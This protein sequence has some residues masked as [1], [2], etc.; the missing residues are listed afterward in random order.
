MKSAPFFRGRFVWIDNDT[1][2]GR[3]RPKVRVGDYSVL[4]RKRGAKALLSQSTMQPDENALFAPNVHSDEIVDG[5]QLYW[6]VTITLYRNATMKYS[7]K[8]TD[9]SVLNG[10]FFP[11]K[12]IIEWN[13]LFCLVE[14]MYF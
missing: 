1:D 11:N 12:Q 2:A 5:R 13:C 9:T 10:H 7:H 8:W 4:V 6:N 14:K 3:R